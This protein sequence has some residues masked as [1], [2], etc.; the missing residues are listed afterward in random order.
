MSFAEDRLASLVER[1]AAREPAP[2]GGAS[3]AFACAFAAALVEMAATFALPAEGPEAGGD[4]RLRELLDRVRELRS[5][6]LALAD[7]D[8]A[9]YGRVIEAY[10]LSPEEPGRAEAIRSALSA[11]AEPP[12]ALTVAAAETAHLGAEI[13]RSGNPNLVGDARTAV[14]LAE[15]ATRAAHGLVEINLADAPDDPRLHRSS[16]HLRTAV[17]ARERVLDD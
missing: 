11:A 16:R 3:A 13:A 15:A 14:L 2:G 1:V 4:G 10:G 7:R 12:L 9:A 8:A 5:E 6:A 17:K